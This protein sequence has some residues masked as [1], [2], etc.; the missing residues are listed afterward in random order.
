MKWLTVKQIKE[1]AR[2][3]DEAAIECSIL[4]YEQV[5]GAT[6]AELVQFG[7]N[8][9]KEWLLNQVYCALC[10]RH[11][12]NGSCQKCPLARYNHCNR[13]NGRY[14]K[15][16]RALIKLVDWNDISIADYRKKIKPML[17]LLKSLRTTP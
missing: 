10:T 4:H 13:D 2:E 17:D 1:A 3:S 9:R 5:M 6:G 12:R 16:N 7:R 11:H 8:N 15:A 14:D